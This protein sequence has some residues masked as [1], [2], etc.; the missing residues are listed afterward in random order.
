MSRLT[1]A[2]VWFLV[3]V[4]VLLPLYELF[5]YTEAWPDD[6]NVILPT[7]AALLAGIALVTG[8][9][10]KNAVAVLIRHCVGTQR[11]LSLLPVR[12]SVPSVLFC[13]PQ[14]KIDLTLA[15]SD[16]RI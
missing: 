10:F 2:G 5:D 14:R 7:L 13:S 15:F 8:V 4:V 9:F 16:L 6:G 12:R 11:L 3:A 1:K